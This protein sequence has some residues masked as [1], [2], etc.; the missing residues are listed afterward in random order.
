MLYGSAINPKDGSVYSYEIKTEFSHGF[1]L[2]GAQ[3]GV[4]KGADR[5]GTPVH[6]YTWK[7]EDILENLNEGE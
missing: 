4:W 1:L 2:T 5:E 7:L 6:T 3:T